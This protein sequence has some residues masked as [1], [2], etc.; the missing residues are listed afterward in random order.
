[1]FLCGYDR[2]MPAQNSHDQ[3][4]HPVADSA[5]QPTSAKECFG[6]GDETSR[7]GI[8]AATFRSFDAGQLLLGIWRAQAV[9]PR[10][11]QLA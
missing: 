9:S 1:M 3:L 2:R 10:D 4:G 7:F 11:P 8:D 5:S 6:V